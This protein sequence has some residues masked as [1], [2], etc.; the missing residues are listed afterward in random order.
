MN[1]SLTAGRSPIHLYKMMIPQVKDQEKYKDVQ[2]YLFDEAP[3]QDK[4]YGP[5]WNEYVDLFFRHANIPEERIH[6]TTLENWG[7]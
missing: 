4:P 1:I 7:S 5:N 3:Y 2:Y 6:T